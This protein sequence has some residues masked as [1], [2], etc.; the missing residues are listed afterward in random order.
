MHLDFFP[1][2]F[3]GD[4]ELLDGGFFLFE[5]DLSGKGTGGLLRSES[6]LNVVSL[7]STNVGGSLLSLAS[8]VCELMK[9]VK[10]EV[11][12]RVRTTEESSPFALD[13][14]LVSASEMFSSKLSRKSRL[15]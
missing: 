7:G 6:R 2:F 14:A 1:L 3:P 8:S 15:S 4:F 5:S 12:S 10:L 11:S 9:Y 13:I